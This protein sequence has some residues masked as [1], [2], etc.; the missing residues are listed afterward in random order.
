LAGRVTAYETR[1]AALVDEKVVAFCDV[2]LDVTDG[3]LSPSLR[4]LGWLTDLQV[5]EDWRNRG[6][7]VGWRRTPSSGSV[8]PARMRTRPREQLDSIAASGGMC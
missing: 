8:L 6:S 2:R 3:G 7:D 4:G 5:R 1:L